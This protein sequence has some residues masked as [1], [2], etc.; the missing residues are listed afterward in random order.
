MMTDP[1]RPV[2]GEREGV[3]AAN[4]PDP[5]DV[6]VPLRDHDEFPP[7]A[8]DWDPSID[9]RQFV[10]LMGASLALAG[11]GAGCTKQPEEHIVPYVEQPENLVPGKPLF[12]ATTMPMAGF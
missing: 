7:G 4:A 5:S 1:P 3:R 6:E 2:L 8:A 10:S 11:V 9:R 12:F